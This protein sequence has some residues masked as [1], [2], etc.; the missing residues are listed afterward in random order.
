MKI[1]L[2][3]QHVPAD[4]AADER[5]VL[6]QVSAITSALAACGH[7]VAVLPC[8]TDLGNLQ[9]KLGVLKPDGVFNLVE[10]LGG[11]GRL[12][13]L[14]PAVWEVMGM[15]FTGSSSEALYLTTHKGL[16]KERML[17]VGLPTPPW[18]VRTATGLPPLLYGAD[19]T[20]PADWIVK[21]VW[22]H[23]SAGLDDSSILRRTPASTVAEHVAG[24]FFAERFIDGREFNLALLVGPDGPEV[25]PPAEIVFVDF[26]AGKPKIV[27][28][29]AKWDEASFEYAHTVR[30]F[31]DASADSAL[32][33]ELKR[34]ALS[35]WE[36]FGLGGY[37]RVD[38]RVDAH[39]KPWILEVNSNPCL[40]PDSGFAAA[41]EKAGIPYADAMDRIV[42]DACGSRGRSPSMPAEG[43]EGRVSSRA[44]QERVPAITWRYE[45]TPADVAAIREVT[46]STGSSTRIDDQML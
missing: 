16:A 7:A 2:I 26:P 39:G 4:A 18:M 28:Y 45:V 15:P 8:T 11:S 25:L 32:L 23:A 30:Q 24:G 19:S 38:F 9:R 13:H 33:A 37:A 21:S 29:Q 20:A 31:A 40:S 27:G 42:R 46:A 43:G 10:T 34:L 1:A 41:L 3:H 36:V 6:D 22:E 17:A 44:A 35:C 12:I 5:D 14:A